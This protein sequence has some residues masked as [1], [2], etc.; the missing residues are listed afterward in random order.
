M[1]TKIRELNV[2]DLKIVSGGVSVPTRQQL[3]ASIGGLSAS[4]PSG[5]NTAMATLQVPTLQATTL[6]IAQRPLVALV[7]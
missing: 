2:A 7:R 1:A 4:L 6:S 5:V 3:I